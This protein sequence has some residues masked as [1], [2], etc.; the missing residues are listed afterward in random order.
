MITKSLLL[1]GDHG[2]GLNERQ[3]VL[4]V[5]PQSRQPRPE[6]TITWPQTRT[7][8]RLFVDRDLVAQRDDF[9][10]HGTHVSETTF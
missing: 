10:L 2:P 1:P 7:R 5:G 6:H 4:P 8:D 9:D 3:S